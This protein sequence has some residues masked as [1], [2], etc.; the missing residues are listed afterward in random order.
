VDQREN[1]TNAQSGGESLGG[2][3]GGTTESGSARAPDS[4]ANTKPKRLSSINQLGEG[5]ILHG[6]K[7][8]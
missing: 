1:K 2:G 6:E 4:I 8:T 7:A 3:G 5:R